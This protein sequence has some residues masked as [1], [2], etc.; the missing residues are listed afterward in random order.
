MKESVSRAAGAGFATLFKAL[1]ALRPDRP[2]HPTGLALSGTIERSTSPTTSGIA[3]IDSLGSN[4]VEGRL[5]RSLGTPATWPDILGLALRIRTDT[6]PSDIL[7][8][9]TGTSRAGR[10]LLLPRRKAGPC[11]FTSLMP[12]KGTKGPV[13]LAALPEPKGP[14]LPAQP[15]AFRQALGGGNWNLGLHHATLTGP[16]TRFGTLTLAAEPT[17]DDTSTR[18]DPTT[19][20]LPGAGTYQWA[21][22][23]R[24]PAYAT[25]RT[26]KPGSA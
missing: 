22:N 5:S 13:L 4:A 11:A 19:H 18:F 17:T 12:Y 24:S 8:A 6:G 7:L 20:P 14:R 16:W 2:I 10:W 15:L 9:S 1:K 3:W 21:S 23:L 26:K 25:A